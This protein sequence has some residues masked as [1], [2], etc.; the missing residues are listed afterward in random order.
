MIRPKQFPFHPEHVPEELK[1]GRFWVCCDADKVPLVAWETYR[2]SSTNPDAWRHYDEAVAALR[3][4]P[5][6]YAGVGRVITGND[7]YVGVDLDAVRD[8]KSREIAPS[9]MTILKNLDSYSEVS[10]SGMGV[11]TWVKARLD[12]SYVKGGLEV[13]QRGRYFTTTG[14]FLPQFPLTIQDRTSEVEALVEREFPRLRH[15]ARVEAESYDGLQVTLVEHLEGVEVLGEVPD[16]AGVKFRIRCPWIAEHSKGDIESG[17]YIGQRDSG[18]LWFQCWHAHC[19]SRGWGEFRRFVRLK[20]KKL[21]LIKKG[22][23]A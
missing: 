3:L 21:Q 5:E 13:Y 22:I 9:A 8:P 16:G 7:I 10:P 12:R 18:G 15:P 11:K 19:A 6:R 17:T 4:H 2:A 14:M 23:Y 20:A 1:A